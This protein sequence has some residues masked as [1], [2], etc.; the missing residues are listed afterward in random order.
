MENFYKSFVDKYFEEIQKK[1]VSYK[2]LFRVNLSPQQRLKFYYELFVFFVTRILFKTKSLFY[3]HNY[4]L[5][6][7]A[8]FEETFISLND[9]Y[10]KKRY[11]E[12]IVF[13]TLN[14]NRYKLNIDLLDAKLKSQ[15]LEQLKIKDE[16]RRFSNIGDL[17]LYDLGTLGYDVKVIHNPIGIL[18]DF[19]YEQ[20]AYKEIFNIQENDIVLDC[21]GATGDT[22][23]YYAAK[24]AKKVYVFEFIQSN[25]EMIN[26]QLENNIHIKEK[27]EIVNKPVWNES[28]IELSYLEKGNSS[29]V[30]AKGVYSKNITTISIDDVVIT[31]NIKQVDLIKMDIEGA[32]IPALKG[33]EKTIKKFKPK[34]AICVY[35]KPDDLIEIP[36]YIK[37]LNPDYEFYFDYYTDIGWE[38]VL[39]A[40]DR[41]N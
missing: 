18:I 1:P 21:G 5:Q 35:H 31:K 8:L 27:I 23:L 34:L 33:S 26:K 37:S 40:I 7:L 12:Y 19:I 4:F 3:N 11:I 38:A 20:Y 2:S 25:I 32:E 41:N 10:S 14:S 28:N 13:N 39:Y 22:A 6:N 9:E 29:R 30:G 16:D 36:K 15:S 24:G 17:S